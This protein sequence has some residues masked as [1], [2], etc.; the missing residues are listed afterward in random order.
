M[1]ICR[2]LLMPNSLSLVGGHSVHFAQFFFSRF[3]KHYFFNSFHQISTKRHTKNPNHWLIW[4]LRF[5]NLPKNEN[6]MAIFVNTGPHRAGNSKR[7]SS[8]SFHVMSTKLFEDIGLPWW[9]TG[10]CFSCQLAK[11]KKHCGTLKF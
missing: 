10:Y 5:G 1:H 3:S 7:Y 6:F 4:L 11:L 8:Y 2:V 9:N